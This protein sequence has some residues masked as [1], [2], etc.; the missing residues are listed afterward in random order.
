[1]IIRYN[2]N[3]SPSSL[4]GGMYATQNAIEL[5]NVLIHNNSAINY[6]GGI[7]LDG[8]ANAVSVLRNVTIADNSAGL[9]NGGID[10][11]NTT[12][13][14]FNTIVYNNA[15]SSINLF[16]STLNASYSVIDSPTT[17]PGT[18]NSTKDP[19]FINNN[20]DN[21]RIAE[22]GSAYNNG[23][24]ADGPTSGIDLD[25][26]DRVKILG[27]DIGAYE[28]Q[29]SDLRSQIAS[30]PQG[31]SLTY[32]CPKK[33]KVGI[34][35]SQPNLLYE[36]YSPAL[37]GS[38]VGDGNDIIVESIDDAKDYNYFLF[39]SRKGFSK[40][41]F[42]SNK[43]ITIP[44]DSEIALVSNEDYTVELKINLDDISGRKRIYS[45]EGA[46]SIAIDGDEIFFT[47]FGNFDFKTAGVDLIAGVDNDIKIKIE[48]TATAMSNVYVWVSGVLKFANSITFTGPTN[49]NEIH[50]GGRPSGEWMKASMDYLQIKKGNKV[51]L[52][53]DFVTGNNSTT[54]FD[55]RALEDGDSPRN[56]TMIGFN[57]V[58]DWIA[59]SDT[60]SILCS[61]VGFVNVSTSTIPVNHIVTN[62]NDAGF[63]TLRFQI[64]EAACPN[65]TIRF[66]NL[67]DPIFV[68]DLISI[69]SDINIIG[70]GMN[71]TIL[72]GENNDNRFFDLPFSYKILMK[73]FQM[74]D[75][76]AAAFYITTDH[77]LENILYKN[78]FSSNF[79][80]IGIDAASNVSVKGEVIIEE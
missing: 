62:S 66:A 16:G 60:E 64:E 79:G 46:F 5:E 45:Q 35:N 76:I 17:W 24:T 75:N 55:L 21:Y 44:Y 59:G 52:R 30:L 34:P 6:G 20:Q 4:G 53:Y 18:G 51:I 22:C 11:F 32:S 42:D 29:R 23:N 74:K 77:T 72:N 25:G 48:P 57:P 67:L 8:I 2:E 7:S 78:V 63:E 70:N 36:F 50:I 37:D 12:T 49:T 27:V 39:A 38:I 28:V 1:M 56:G 3:A 68:P 15:P 33:V 13:E 26:N 65:D 58:T 54:V 80:T 61:P 71:Q 19:I 14:F 73:D 40:L 41:D 47:E 43:R 69:K 31:I 10:N 9:D